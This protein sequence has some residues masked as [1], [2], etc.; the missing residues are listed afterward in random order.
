MKKTI[1]TGLLL[2]AAAAA[3]SQVR[4]GGLITFDEAL[5]MTAS[6]NERIK[7]SE[8]EQEAAI[9]Q[10]K[11]AAG[12]RL[13]SVNL[14]GA[15][16]VMSDDIGVDLN[17]AKQPVGTMLNG[18]SGALPAEAAAA[19]GQISG[20]LMAKDWALTIQD[21]DFGA[22]GAGITVPV[23]TGGKI[24]A[25]N[26]A[27]EIEVRTALESGNETSN[28]LVSELA[29]RYFGLALAIQVI[30]VREQVLEGMEHHLSDAR[31]ME[32]HGM[33][34]K[35]ERL[36]AEMQVAE[37]KKEV[38]KSVR[39]A[40]TVNTALCNTINTEGDF[41]PA[42]TMFIVNNLES[43]EYFK[44]L[45]L[46]NSPLLRQVSLKADLAQEGV[47]A[48]KADFMPQVALMGVYDIYSYQVSKAIPQW[49][50]GAGVKIK[51]FDGLNREYKYSAAKSKAKQVKSLKSKAESDI[52]TLVDKTYNEL[53]TCAEQIDAISVSLEFAEEYLRMQEISFREGASSSSDVVDARLNLAKIRTE[54]LQAAF[55]YDVLLARLLE[56][57]GLSQSY[58]LYISQ[59]N[60]TQIKL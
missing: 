57:C 27:A 49:A 1:L 14:T 39:D 47:R 30:E 46:Q 58:P 25:A 56:I 12:L 40:A 16:A 32:E 22:V 33:I 4:S 45:A 31:S 48:Q 43:K 50:V 55:T 2:F 59:K 34:A 53:L 13:P 7:A 8:F 29:E 51:I 21:R 11:A 10:K 9:K 60:T 6:R 5:G 35:V 37:A 38:L 28:A 52:L 23:Y 15:Y 20:Q 3:H 26:R 17:H 41:T 19:I 18:L 44:E 42:T 36:Y 54:K 24:N